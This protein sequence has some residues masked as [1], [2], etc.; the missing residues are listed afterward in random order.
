MDLDV[1]HLLGPAA[2]VHAQ[3]FG[4]AVFGDVV[5]A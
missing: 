2:V 4:A 3:G 5:E 1:S